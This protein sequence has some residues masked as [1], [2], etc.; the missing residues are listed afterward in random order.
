VGNRFPENESRAPGPAMPFRQIPFALALAIFLAL[1][2]LPASSGGTMAEVAAQSLRGSPESLDRQNAQA[3]AHNFTYLETP[4]QVRRYVDLGYLVPVRPTAHMQIHNVSFPYARPEVR[5]FLERLSSQYRAACGEQLVVTSLTRPLSNQPPNASVRS[6]HPTGMAVDLRR[7]A[8]ARCRSWLESTLLS[9]ERQGLI[10]A[11]VERRP[12]HYHIAVYPR[13][14]AQYVARITG[15][16][17]VVARAGDGG[18]SA[19]WETHEIRPGETLS[20]IAARHGT[21]VTRLRTENNLRGN[22]ILVGQRL[23]VP[24]Y[25]DTA[26]APAATPVTVQAM[27]ADAE[28]PEDAVDA[29]EP[30]QSTLPGSSAISATESPAA[31]TATHRVARGESLWTIARRYGVAEAELRR[32]NGISGSRILVGQELTIPIGGGVGAGSTHRVA[33]GESL[34]TIARRYGVTEADL[35]R[36]NGVSG[37]RILVGQELTI[38]GGGASGPMLHRVAQGESLWVIARRHGTTV[39]DLRRANGIGSS[40][41]ILPGQEL[42]IPVGR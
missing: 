34:W 35:R 41:R 26:P 32:A 10:E 25:V 9:L 24:V 8:N 33:R 29:D 42:L 17:P 18:A 13:P 22:R 30:T 4:A 12:P 5:L 11:I 20:G 7:S 3:R 19:Q 39:D 21:T 15:D 40:G 27:A 31:A 14:Y 38:P 2:A 23:R 16:R 37:S 28:G 1:P 6:V 36:A